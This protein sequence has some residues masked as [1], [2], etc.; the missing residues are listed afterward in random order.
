[1]K[2]FPAIHL[3]DGKAV[4]LNRGRRDGATVYGE[5]PVA[6]VA[7]FAAAGAERIH[8]VDLDGAFSGSS[9]QG[10]LLARMAEASSVPLQV[11]GGIRDRESLDALFGLGIQFAI[12]GTAAVKN[13]RFVKKACRDHQERI[14]V[15]VD[16]G[17]DGQVAVEG[18]TEKSDKT[19]LEVSTRAVLWGA[20][21]LLYT[22]T[23]RDGTDIG[24]NV[25]AVAA[26]SHTVDI[27]V[28]AAGG[29]SSLK[30]LGELA[31]RDVP[32]V[33]VGHALYKK[34]FTLQEAIAA[35]GEASEG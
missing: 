4:C 20:A 17:D 18:W 16:S 1:M 10:D 12:L 29:V 3:L 31:A 6:L 5:D 22:D 9:V 25:Q 19:A 15:A 35:A 24:P 8:V 13:R 14:I 7:E 28:I 11:G 30:D 32:V 27:P 21:A 34:T 23:D 33:I 26:L 2:V